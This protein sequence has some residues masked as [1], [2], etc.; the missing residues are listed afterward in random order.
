MIR[1]IVILF[2]FLIAACTPAPAP[3]PKNWHGATTQQLFKKLGYPARVARL[4]HG[5][6]LLIYKHKTSP[7]TALFKIDTKNK[8]VSV[9]YNG[10]KQ[11]PGLFS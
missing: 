10:G 5:R 11:C 4:P 9:K 8:I 1:W 3:T 6:Q 7:C 2:C